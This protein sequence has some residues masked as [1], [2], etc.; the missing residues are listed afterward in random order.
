MGVI[1]QIVAFPVMVAMVAAGASRQKI[2]GK[3]Q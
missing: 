1:R 2:R 3:Q